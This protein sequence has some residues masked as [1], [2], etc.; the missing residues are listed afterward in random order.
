MHF[1]YIFTAIALWYDIVGLVGVQLSQ[2]DKNGLILGRKIV[3][4]GSK[5]V[6]RLG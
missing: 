4:F 2:A 3:T 5:D 6:E 1:I